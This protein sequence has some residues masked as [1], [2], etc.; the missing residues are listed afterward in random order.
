MAG[1]ANG[2]DCGFSI[3]MVLTCVRHEVLPKV[4]AGQTGLLP[5]Q[6][7]G[8]QHDTS[9]PT[10]PLAFHPGA[11]LVL[12]RAPADVDDELFCQARTALLDTAPAACL[13]RIDEDAPT[14][15][16]GVD[17]SGRISMRL[18]QQPS[19]QPR[20]CIFPYHELLGHV[21]LRLLAQGMPADALNVIPVG[22]LRRPWRVAAGDALLMLPTMPSS[23]HRLSKSKATIAFTQSPA[24]VSQAT[25]TLAPLPVAATVSA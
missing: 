7:P 4:T 24:G 16:A 22:Q 6:C 20:L 17:S 5:M 10:Q 12:I 13:L 19:L 11:Q 9:F 14:P 3:T 25:L 8:Y 21:A 23:R 1:R 15:G 18:L 2:N